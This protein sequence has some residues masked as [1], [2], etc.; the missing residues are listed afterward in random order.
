M[1]NLL[2]GISANCK[3]IIVGDSYQLPSVG[4]G[5]VLHDLIS[6]EK[7]EVVELNQLYRQKDDSNIITLAYD[8]RN[9]KIDKQ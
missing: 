3:V 6:S 5:Q 9:K 1:A 7:L 8:I 2:R 4:P